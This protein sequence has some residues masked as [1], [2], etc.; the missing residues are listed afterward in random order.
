AGPGD[1]NGDGRPDLLVGASQTDP[2]DAGAAYVV[3]GKKDTA[4]VDLGALGARGFEISGAAGG[5]GAGDSV[6]GAGDVNGDGK[7]DVLLGALGAEN[8]GRVESGSPY[9][10]FGKSDAKRVDLAALGGGGCR[11]DGPE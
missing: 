7:A 5:D 8:N 11:M 2:S 10:V 6:S 4:T 1:V 3:F 9:V